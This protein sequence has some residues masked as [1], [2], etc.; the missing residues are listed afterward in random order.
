MAAGVIVKLLFFAYAK[1]ETAIAKNPTSMRATFDL[2]SDFCFS[3][4]Q[5][6]VT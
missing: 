2:T 1:K 3:T 5:R 6:S 4:C